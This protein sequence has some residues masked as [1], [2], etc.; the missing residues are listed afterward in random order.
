MSQCG[1]YIF[2][3]LKLCQV[4]ILISNC[5][6]TYSSRNCKFYVFQLLLQLLRLLSFNEFWIGSFQYANWSINE[7]IAHDG[8]AELKFAMIKIHTF[9]ITLKTEFKFTYRTSARGFFLGR[10]K[11]YKISILQF[12]YRCQLIVLSSVY[13]YTDWGAYE[14]KFNLS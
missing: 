12:S 6:H 8:F 2:I 4:G 7:M 9:R 1:L 11:N 13:C 10:G 5:F 14:F 3:T